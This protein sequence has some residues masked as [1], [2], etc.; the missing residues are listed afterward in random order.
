MSNPTTQ[1][2]TW[3]YRP[4]SS[5]LAAAAI[6]SLLLVLSPGAFAPVSAAGAARGRKPAALTIRQV[7]VSGSNVTVAGVV[8]ARGRAAAR[9]RVLLT[10]AGTG[11]AGPGVERFTATP[12]AR[13]IFRVLHRTALSGRL[14]L[15][16]SLRI[17]GRG[18]GAA[19]RR[20][21]DVLA[22]TG[23]PGGP[24]AGGGAPGGSG[25]GGSGG[26]G[27][28]PP[29]PTVLNGTF[30]LTA[31]TET[32]GAI[33][34]SWFEMFIP[35][36]SAPLVNSNSPLGNRDFTPL[37]S[38]T[39]GG[40]RTGG[41]QAAPTPAFS[42]MKSG[43]PVGNSLAGAIIQPQD[44]FG[45]NFGVVTEATDPQ[46][47]LADPLAHILDTGGHLSGQVT[48]WAVGWNGQWFNQGSP[49][50]DGTL[51]T[52]TTPVSGSYDAATGH[53]VLEWR[54]LIVGGPFNNFIGA[55]HLEGT[56]VPSS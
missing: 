52:G 25:G 56:F 1:S 4:S 39:D 43:K 30:Q 46:A 5:R 32:A 49:K 23:T 16:A 53:Y 2:S 24:P 18:A 33:S 41:Y 44:F 37:S 8:R 26:S 14:S 38:G 19:I 48:A 51:P 20:S 22:P 55:W 42:E 15:L 29:I 3:G 34:G 13:G 47:A 45:Y 7:S 36:G 35:G 27:G 6:V 10:L 21:L 28:G 40:L 17:R 50:P 31:A 12:S 9:E 54:S 11:P